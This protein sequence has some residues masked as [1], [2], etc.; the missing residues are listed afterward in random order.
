MNNINKKYSA[1]KNSIVFAIVLMMSLMA[2]AMDLSD[3]DDTVDKFI[4]ARQLYYG[5]I[6]RSWE[7]ANKQ[8]TS[9]DEINTAVAGLLRDVC[10][11]FT[12]TIVRE[13]AGELYAHMVLSY[14]V[15]TTLLDE[16]FANNAARHIYAANL[17]QKARIQS[18]YAWIAFANILYEG[19]INRGIDGEQFKDRKER[20]GSAMGI[21]V[22]FPIIGSSKILKA[23]MLYEGNAD[24][25]SVPY[26]KDDPDGPYEVAAGL[27]RKVGTAG[28]KGEATLEEKTAVL[29]AKLHYARMLRRGLTNEGFEKYERVDSSNS[30]VQRNRYMCS[31][32]KS[33]AIK[34][35]EEAQVLP[36]AQIELAGMFLEARRDVEKS[37]Q[38]L[39]DVGTPDAKAVFA[40]NLYY[41]SIK[42]PWDTATWDKTKKFDPAMEKTARYKEAVRLA[43]EADTPVAWA[44]HAEMAYERYT[45]TSFYDPSRQYADEKERMAEVLE[46]LRRSGTFHAKALFADMTR[47]G[48]NECTWNDPLKKYE[49]GEERKAEIVNLLRQANTGEARRIL[50]E[51]GVGL[52]PTS[53]KIDR[54]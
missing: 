22:R 21:C 7:D 17:F 35:L 9:K 24:P 34:L 2:E 23:R 19:W 12:S 40:E 41:G 53:H 54:K 49:N 37:M 20:L 11:K 26:T 33:A 15:N 28:L 47:A 6:N 32:P 48:Y 44:L 14:E 10:M 16:L 50:E 30:D 4:F 18:Q 46:L 39:R 5:K 38:T 3:K 52:R 8:Y 43:K 42:E 25:L 1:I 36:L 27:L 29:E 51:M 45:D 31:D 13:N